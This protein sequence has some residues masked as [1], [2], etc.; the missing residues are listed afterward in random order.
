MILVLYR[1][2]VIGGLAQGAPGEVRFC[3]FGELELIGEFQRRIVRT[4]I[5]EWDS[6]CPPPPFLARHFPRAR[7]MA[8]SAQFHP[9][10]AAVSQAEA[11]ATIFPPPPRGFFAQ[12]ANA[13]PAGLCESV[14]PCTQALHMLA[15]QPVTR[16]FANLRP[17]SPATPILAGAASA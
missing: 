16:R 6:Q 4:L 1:H 5:C 2:P 17:A 14:G 12:L 13:E 15:K 9:Q 11:F 7:L 10:A 3:G 8:L